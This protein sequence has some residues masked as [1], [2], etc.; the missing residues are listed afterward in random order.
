M[1][2][3][4]TG[5]PGAGKSWYCVRKICNAL[6][7]GK[8]VATNVPLVDGWA[9]ALAGRNPK[10]VLG[11]RRAVRRAA[12]RYER[13]LYLVEDLQ[14]L[15][16]VRLRGKGEGRG[17]AVLDE[18]HEWLNSR[19]WEDSDRKPMVSW[20]S[21]HRHYGWDVY[22][23]TQYL[24]SVDK[25]VRDRVEYHVVLRNLHNAKVAGVRLFPFNLF[26]A[27]HLWAG[28]PA[29]LKH[30]S[31]REAFKL[32]GRRKLYDT[33]G[34]AWDLSDGEDALWLPRE[35]GQSAGVR[36]GTRREPAA[37]A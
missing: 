25:Q 27:I 18:A 11:G 20:F 21:R 10:Y 30:V 28:G 9:M 15:M 36:G 23:V 16:R 7:A 8:P 24:D 37:D 13:S 34:L 35:V 4:V 22:L 29:T 3:A 19:R 12:D 31:K 6:Q 32:D 33:H 5:T 26:L 17:V 1:I 14:E 2:Y